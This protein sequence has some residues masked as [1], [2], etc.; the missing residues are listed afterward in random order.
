MLNYYNLITTVP[1]GQFRAKRHLKY[2]VADCYLNC[3]TLTIYG[4]RCGLDR[5][6]D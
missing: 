6:R 4:I 1:F 5:A 3:V 2:T